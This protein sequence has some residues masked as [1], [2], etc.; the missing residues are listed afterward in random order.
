MTEAVDK[1]T[2][3]A[4]EANPTVI[5]APV[6]VRSLSL[7][8][9][10]VIAAIMMLQYMQPVLIPI[11]LAVL[12]SYALWPIVAALARLKIPHSVGA[13]IAVFALVGL[14]GFG[15]WAFSD[16][17]MGIVRDVPRAAKQLRDRAEAHQRK[18]R[19]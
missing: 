2:A 7:S 8:V 5:S 15:V 9:I 1:Q 11:V 12:I 16:E 19:Q 18:A 10:A 4:Q 13:A 14:I 3:E 6:D 17:A